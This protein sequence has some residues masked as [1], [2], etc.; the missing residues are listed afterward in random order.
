[1]IW[2]HGAPLPHVCLLSKEPLI[3]RLYERGWRQ[4]GEEMSRRWESTNNAVARLAGSQAIYFCIGLLLQGLEVFTK[5]Q[6]MGRLAT[7]DEIAALVIYLAS[8]EVRD[9][10]TVL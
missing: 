1:M 2:L 3:P 9:L 6:K 4:W 5:R 7:A 10:S 8:E